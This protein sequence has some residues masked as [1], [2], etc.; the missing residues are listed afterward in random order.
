MTT[1][2]IWR[3]AAAAVLGLMLGGAYFGA[4]WWTVRRLPRTPHPGL[5]L[6]GSF[7]VRISLTLGVFYLLL[8]QGIGLLAA[9]MFGF[10]LAR[11]VWLHLKNPRG[12]SQ[13]AH[14]A[15]ELRQ[16]AARDL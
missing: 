7:A 10:L 16:G 9:S 8:Q 6:G 13:S 2:E 14:K 4:L 12:R 1:T 3:L 5:W 15:G 11:F